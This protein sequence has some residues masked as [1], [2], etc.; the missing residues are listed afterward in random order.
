M[1]KAD[2]R[3]IKRSPSNL[4]FENR[5][6]PPSWDQV[7]R[8][9]KLPLV[10]T[11]CFSLGFLVL[12]A[13]I[14]WQVTELFL[15]YMVKRTAFARLAEEEVAGLAPI[16]FGELRRVGASGAVPIIVNSDKGGS[17]FPEESEGNVVMMEGPT[18]PELWEDVPPNGN[19]PVARDGQAVLLPRSVLGGL[20]LVRPTRPELS[21][22]NRPFMD[23]FFR[24]I[25]GM[26]GVTDGS[27]GPTSGG[28]V[29]EPGVLSLLYLVMFGL[30]RRRR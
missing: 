19:W 25:P 8:R 17:A 30:L 22:P 16:E 5:W 28:S 11:R 9:K 27:G 1:P 20:E 2:H 12:I 18:E 26:S 21:R 10:V 6:S 14:S 4:E 7:R 29:P 24:L 13:G 23:G 3:D 15:G